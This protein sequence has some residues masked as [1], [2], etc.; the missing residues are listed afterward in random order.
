[1]AERVQANFG[2]LLFVLLPLFAA[3]LLAVN[4]RQRMPYSAHLVFALHLHAFWFI[5]L[6]VMQ[7]FMQIPWHPIVWIGGAVMVGYTLMAGRLIYPDRRPVRLLRAGAL[8][9]LLFA[10]CLQ[11]VYWN[12]RLR[13]AEHLVFALHL[14][15]V[16]F[17]V[18]ARDEPDADWRLPL[19]AGVLARQ[20]PQTSI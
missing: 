4:R 3:C 13:Y 15:A 5:V 8:T 18:L 11:I 2:A 9:L 10:L 17:L 7:L 16:W 1:M 19:G 12:R 14:H 20:V 6:A